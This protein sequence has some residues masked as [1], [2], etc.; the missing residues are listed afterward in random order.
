MV[1][2]ELESDHPILRYIKLNIRNYVQTLVE[3]LPLFACTEKIVLL[4]SG[5]FSQVLSHTSADCSLKTTFTI[6]ILEYKHQKD[7][8]TSQLPI[9]LMFNETFA[10]KDKRGSFP[11]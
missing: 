5:P 7:L 4:Q 8:H 11:K 2:K 6:L 1:F 3:C 10:D 9:S